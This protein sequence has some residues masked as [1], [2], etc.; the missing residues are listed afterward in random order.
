M[1]KANWSGLKFR[2]AKHLLAWIRSHPLGEWIRSKIICDAYRGVLE[3]QEP[4]VV[5]L[6]SDG[7]VN[8][9]A[10]KRVTVNVV[11]RPHLT[12]P[13]AGPKLDEYVDGQ[14]SVRHRRVYA[15]GSLRG[16][17]RCERIRPSDIVRT[18]DTLKWV[19]TLDKIGERYG[20]QTVYGEG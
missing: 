7:T 4:V 12:Q 19:D 13:E 11:Q 20:R 1:A 3:D 9:Y 14:L 15:P 8:V 18:R 5:E 16:V 10:S 17:G 2:S 6:Y